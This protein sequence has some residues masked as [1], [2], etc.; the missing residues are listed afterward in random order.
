MDVR[1]LGRHL[2]G[3]GPAAKRRWGRVAAPLSLPDTKLTFLGEVG[4][5]DEKLIF[6]ASGD[7]TVQGFGYCRASSSVTICQSLEK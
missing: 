5:I 7:G 3:V 4:E 1:S 2:A 6:L